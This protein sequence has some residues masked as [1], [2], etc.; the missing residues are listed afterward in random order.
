MNDTAKRRALTFAIAGTGAIG[1]VLLD[2][3]LPLLLGPM[4]ACLIAAL[5]A[6]I[7]FPGLVLWLPRVFGYPG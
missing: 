3:P 4:L 7:L 2:L 6:L 1:F 5:G